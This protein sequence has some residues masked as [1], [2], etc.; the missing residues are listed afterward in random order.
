MYKRYPIKERLVKKISKRKKMDE[1]V[2]RLIADSPL[3]FTRDVMANPDD[4]RSVRIRYFA[5]FTPKYKYLS[6]EEKELYKNY[7]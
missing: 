6:D 1:R 5:A 3:K 2:V 4:P 7:I